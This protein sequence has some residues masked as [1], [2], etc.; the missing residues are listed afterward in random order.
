MA[1]KTLNDLFVHTLRDIYYAEKQVLKAL[2]RMAKK[3]SNDK[4]RE[5][6]EHHQQE[7]EQQIE[8]LEQV[9]EMLDMKPRGVTCE[10]INGIIEEAKDI[11]SEADE[12]DVRD[13]GMTAAAQAVEHYEI[14]RYGTMIAWANTLGKT[15]AAKIFEEILKQEKAADEKLTALAEEALNKQAA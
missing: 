7:T 8:K 10:A 13:A 14:S 3:A 15:D 6:F 1:M 12:D 5:A 4:L 2:P 11:M 9:F